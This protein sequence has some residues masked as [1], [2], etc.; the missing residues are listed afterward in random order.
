MSL[1]ATR[2]TFRPV[3]R[4]IAGAAVVAVAVAVALAGCGSS[5]AS[6]TPGGPA[7]VAPSVAP[8]SSVALTPIPTASGGRPPSPG[9]TGPT[10]TDLTWGRIWDRLPPSFPAIPDAQATA[11]TEPATAALITT[12][13]PSEFAVRYVA[14]LG[15]SGYRTDGATSPLEDGSLVLDSVPNTAISTACRIQAHVTVQGGAT[16]V[17]I[18]V[19]AACPFQ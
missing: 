8:T 14:A 1:L 9:S 15:A 6:A 7:S 16:I 18:L 3:G 13:K 10:T 5:T 11:P 4:S 17:T 2:S 19:A 12:L